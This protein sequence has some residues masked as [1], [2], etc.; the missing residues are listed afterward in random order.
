MRNNCIHGLGQ[1]KHLAHVGWDA[2]TWHVKQ[3]YLEARGQKRNDFVTLES[4]CHVLKMHTLWGEF[5]FVH[6][7]MCFMIG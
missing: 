1:A 7:T 4:R 3:H 5:C 6:D 2:Y